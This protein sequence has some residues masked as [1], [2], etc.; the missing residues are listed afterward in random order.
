MDIWKPTDNDN[1]AQN[2]Y[3][4]LEP[5][6]VAGMDFILAAFINP[7]IKPLFYGSH[8]KRNQTW[9]SCVHAAW[10]FADKRLAHDYKRF[11]LTNAQN[12]RPNAVFLIIEIPQWPD[13]LRP[14]DEEVE[15]FT[16]TIKKKWHEY[17]GIRGE[18]DNVKLEIKRPRRLYT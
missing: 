9:V 7:D 15:I 3:K 2:P 11:L 10:R 17:S 6:R 8:S 18:R 14:T 13:A 4:D 5:Y 1:D 16:Q 12:G